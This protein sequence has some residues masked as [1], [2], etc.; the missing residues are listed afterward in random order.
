MDF[1]TLRELLRQI[2]SMWRDITI[3]NRDELLKQLDGWLDEMSSVREMLIEND[4]DKIHD[5]FSELK[6]S[7]MTCQSHLKVHCI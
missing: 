4:P 5:L 6:N 2:Q 1:G 3:Q 7:E